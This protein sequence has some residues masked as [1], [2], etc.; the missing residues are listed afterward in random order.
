MQ[1]VCLFWEGQAGSRG[2]LLNFVQVCSAGGDDIIGCPQTGC[3]APGYNRNTRA[4]V[5]SRDLLK[6]SVNPAGGATGK[7]KPPALRVVV[8]CACL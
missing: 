1:A 3:F 4:F 8:D 6:R 5:F 7:S 2:D